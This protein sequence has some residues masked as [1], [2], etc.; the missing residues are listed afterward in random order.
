MHIIDYL[1]KVRGHK[2]NARNL[3]NLNITHTFKRDWRRKWKTKKRVRDFILFFFFFFFLHFRA[4]PMAYRG[5]Q[6]RGPIGAV[7]AGLH[8]SSR[9]CQILNPLC[10]AGDRTCILMDPG[11]ARYIYEH[12]FPVITV[13]SSYS[14]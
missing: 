11:Q 13:C 5:S 7:V 12:V 3:T 2:V 10:E 1:I 4:L 14:S 6:A 9:Q 8:H